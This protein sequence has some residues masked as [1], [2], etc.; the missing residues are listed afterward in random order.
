[1]TLKNTK[2]VTETEKKKKKGKEIKKKKERKR[3]KALNIIL[4]LI[5]KCYDTKY[6]LSLGGTKIFIVY[7]GSV[8][9]RQ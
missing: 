5:K 4:D 6:K 8:S 9:Y 1:M 7:I 3:R 2:D